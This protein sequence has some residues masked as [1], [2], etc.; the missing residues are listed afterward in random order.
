MP[1]YRSVHQAGGV[2]E[3]HPNPV[4][5]PQQGRSREKLDR[6]LIAGAQLFGERGF[7]GTRIS[8]VAEL[9]GCSVGVFYQRF[10]DKDAFFAAVRSRWIEQARAALEQSLEAIPGSPTAPQLVRLIVHAALSLFRE[11]L[12]LIRAFLIYESDHPESSAPMLELA[13]SIADRQT[14][15]WLEHGLVEGH[16]EPALAVRFALE[17]L[18]ATLVYLVLRS[19]EA[20]LSLDDERLPRELERMLGAYLGAAG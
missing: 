9:G 6:L 20:P 2:V 17:V 15:R 12:G 8:D 11:H 3:T 1:Q 16:P 13:H 19:D 18:R 5:R 7:D 10:A 4:P 14:E